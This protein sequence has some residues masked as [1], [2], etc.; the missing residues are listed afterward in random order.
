MSNDVH[1]IF[2]CK[3]FI[4]TSNFSLF[5]SSNDIHAIFYIMSNDIHAYIFLFFFYS[6]C[7]FDNTLGV[8]IFLIATSNIYFEY[9][10]P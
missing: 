7:L 8:Y 6:L 2:Y 9:Y 3:H 1:A 5:I 10:R 4:N